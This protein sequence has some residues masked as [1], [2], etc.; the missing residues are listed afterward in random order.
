M[1]RILSL[2][3]SISLILLQIPALAAEAEEGTE[4]NP[5]RITTPE[6][7]QSINNN[8]S[9]YYRLENDINMTGIE[10]EPIGS[11]SVGAFKGTLDGNG[12][13]ISNL[14]LEKEGNKYVGLIGC[15]EG[16]VKNINLDNVIVNGQAARYV[17]AVA[18]YADENAL[19]E[20]C[21]TLSGSVTGSFV[22]VDFYMGGIVGYNNGIISNCINA[23]KVNHNA[24]KSNIYIGGMT[25]YN[26]KIIISSENR[27][28]VTALR[29]TE[30]SDHN[31]FYVGGITCYN[32]GEI[33]NCT[34]N[35][36]ISITVDFYDK[37]LYCCSTYGGG[38]VGINS[39]KIINCMNNATIEAKSHLRSNS[40]N[41]LYS[42][43][44]TGGI[45]GKTTGIINICINNGKI[46]S[47]SNATNSVSY[48]ANAYSYAG[49][50]SGYVYSSK[51]DSCTNAGNIN[52]C[53]NK[54]NNCG[55][56]AYSSGIVGGGSGKIS[57]CSNSGTILSQ[58]A[59]TV[60][61]GGICSGER[62]ST[63]STA[64]CHNSGTIKSDT[65]E[66]ACCGGISSTLYYTT[67][68]CVNTG[69]LIHSG[70]ETS[71]ETY[72]LA[73]YVRNLYIKVSKINL[74]QNVTSAIPIELYGYDKDLK[75]TSSD[76]SVAVV[77]SK[78]NV[79]GV[80][81][82]EAIITAETELGITTSTTVSVTAG[83]VGGADIVS[84]NKTSARLK[85][86]ETVQLTAEVTPV[87]AT[88]PITWSSKDTSIA[89]VNSNGLVTAVKTGVTTITARIGSGRM[90]NC[91]INVVSDDVRVDV[92]SV[93]IDKNE[94]ILAP[95]DAAALNAF[96]S[97]TNATDAVIKYTSDNESVA[98]VNSSG[99][100]T[101]K[102]AGVAVIRAEASNGCYDECVISVVSAESSSV[103]L[104]A[105]KSLSGDVAEVKASIVKN[106]GIC[107]YKILLEY[108]ST[109][110]TPISITP[111]EAFKG[112]FTSNLEDE[113]KTN[114]Q[115]LWYSD[116]DTDYNAELFSVTF[117]VSGDAQIGDKYPV[118][119]KCSANDICNTNG[120]KF[121]F[122]TQNTE[123]TIAE[124]IPGDVHE[125]GDVTVYDLTLLARYI[126][127][128]E[129]F[130]KRQ[131]TAGD[132][133]NDG[134]VDIK[135]VV[136]MS[137]YLVGWSGI[138]LMSLL[139]DEP[140]SPDIR[141]GNT[142][143]NDDG[144]AQIP[145]SINNNSGIAGFAFELEY[146]RDQIE[147]LEIIPNERFSENLKTNLG[148]TDD[149][150]LFVTWYNSDNVNGDGVL[151]TIKARYL[152]DAAEPISIKYNENNICDENEANIKVNYTNGTIMSDS[153]V[154]SDEMTENN[155]YSA[156]LYF[157]DTFNEQ[158]A[159][160]IVALYDKNN[161]LAALQTT[162]LVVKPGMQKISAPINTGDYA[163]CKLFIWNSIDSMKPV[164]KQ[165]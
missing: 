3:V 79:T 64:N 33:K 37:F 142:A 113:N 58:H 100:V 5:Y 110:L 132:V 94:I 26:N 80:G 133:N 53:A 156:N 9:A 148:K 143:V 131:L 96:V 117:K 11:E 48:C 126:T 30:T 162:D 165:N 163:Y 108:D 52:S 97:P 92:Q 134:A 2:L 56:T 67:Y 138:T 57:N 13:T 115:I 23:A 72:D 44:Y 118:A 106:P 70:T 101:A 164:V 112:T 39:S 74:Q 66:S 129:K 95:N 7:L 105:E 98:T 42:Y 28:I 10:F 159:I 59:G 145:V 60:Y 103:V 141:L 154:K 15:L 29:N 158:P 104:K 124:P 119:A 83:G 114:L 150:G 144:I 24:L 77:D 88:N 160:A 82:G 49:G 93:T 81:V 65:L 146:N 89:T 102:K 31:N 19:M 22:M 147:I 14:N 99:I 84:I 109:A 68:N 41:V 130:T 45:S 1:K 127:H 18:A 43:L 20:N 123:I 61:S 153:F 47:E 71:K 137:Q 116:E 78:G 35:G 51:I 85:P 38:I 87:G 151:F 149:E 139:N 50:I 120:D 122:Y 8:L 157:D 140:V 32:A 111:N 69:Q 17:G 12:F 62:K 21:K 135:D 73:Y 76:E 27:G 125:D 75:W 46:I 54:I 161:A 107:A 152:N 16:T 136:R 91:V 121:A 6:E 40:N 128:L 34:N 55:S 36:N 63:P 86:T 25:G 4:Q 155:T 90:F